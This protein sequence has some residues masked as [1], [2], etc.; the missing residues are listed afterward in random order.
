MFTE[1]NI[2]FKIYY[3]E[4][5]LQKQKTWLAQQARNSSPSPGTQM[6][7]TCKYTEYSFFGLF[8]GKRN[9]VNVLP[10]AQLSQEIER[11]FSAEWLQEVCFSVDVRQLGK[12]Q[13]NNWMEKRCSKGVK[14]ITFDPFFHVM[15]MSAIK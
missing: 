6:A 13:S 4:A 8:R 10:F 2:I 5:V 1:E 15:E 9:Y 11:L 14:T 7:E 3:C 12:L